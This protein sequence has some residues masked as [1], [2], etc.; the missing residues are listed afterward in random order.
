MAS[1][2]PTEILWYSDS[3]VASHMTQV[4][5]GNGQLLPIANI[6]KIIIQTRD[7]LLTLNSVLHVSQLKHKLLSMRC[8]CRKEQLSCSVF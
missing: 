7:R 4:E 2:M 1:F 3:A 8:L 6:G 5:V